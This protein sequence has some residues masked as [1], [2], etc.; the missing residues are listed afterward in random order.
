[1]RL[2]PLPSLSGHTKTRAPQPSQYWPRFFS[3]LTGA[4]FPVTSHRL[5]LGLAIQKL[6]LVLE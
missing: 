4:L 1:M 3:H 2:D 6:F 5:R